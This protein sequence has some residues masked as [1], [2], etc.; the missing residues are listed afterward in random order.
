MSAATIRNMRGWFRSETRSN[1]SDH[2]DKSGQKIFVR[3][4]VGEV[5]RFCKSHGLHPKKIR[6][7]ANKIGYTEVI[8]TEN[9]TWC[10]SA[11]QKRLEE[12][13]W[14]VL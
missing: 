3:A 11:I 6:V 12:A 9:P 13:G 5:K 2:H 1:N 8:H 4:T 14:E 7:A 10:A